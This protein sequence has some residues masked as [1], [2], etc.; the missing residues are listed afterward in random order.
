MDEAR[1]PQAA[2]LLPAPAHHSGS[3]KET[4][5][6][7]LVAFVLAFIFRAF[8]VEA[9]VIPTGSMAPTLMGAHMRFQCPDC[10]YRFDVNYT[11]ANANDS[12]D[13]NIPSNAGPITQ[14]I[15]CPNCGFRMDPAQVGNPPVYSG[16]RILV[17]K[18]LYLFEQAKRWDVVVFKAPV[19]PAQFNYSQNYIKR[20][21]GKPGEAVMVLDGDVYIRPA[22]AKDPTD[23]TIQTKP[24]AAQDALWRLVYDND[25]RPQMLDRGEVAGWRMPWT[26][27]D[28]SGWALDDAATHGRLLKFDNPAGTS[29]LGF[30]PEA[31]PTAQTLS[32]YLVYDLLP[33]AQIYKSPTDSYPNI[34]ETPVSDLGLRA[35]YQRLAGDGP[36]ELQLT[37]RRDI[38]TA[39]ITPTQA[40]LYH[41]LTGKRT[42]IGESFPLPKSSGPIRLELSNADYQVTLRVNDQIVAQTTPSQYAPD[43]TQLLSEFRE[44]QLQRDN[45]DFLPP[46][47]HARIIADRET[48]QL[49]HV[50]L[51]RDVYYYNSN[52]PVNGILWGTPRD[53]PN[54]VQQL[55]PD[56]Y[57]VMGDNSL[58]SYDA[59]CWDDPINLPGEN[60]VLGAGRVPGRFLLGKA[61]FV[62]WPAGYRP[63]SNWPPVVPNFGDMRFIH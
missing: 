21:I 34:L 48:C 16:D 23:F 20:L 25:F 29:T 60:L 15:Y 61:F 58:V 3:V 32:D 18:Y 5:E 7:I 6:S 53:F 10:G 41:E 35:T 38:F 28:G 17:L 45:R 52:P 13:I 50:S 62:Y 40:T 26:V 47:P 54:H 2:E 56:E 4:L 11:S 19:R 49:S 42:Q 12:D 14:P 31:N 1:S 57:F 8:V 44:Q 63:I 27:A 37:K 22:N 51:W 9:F 59:R 24:K 39:V 46:P 33:R 43:L 55:G 36:F 30:N